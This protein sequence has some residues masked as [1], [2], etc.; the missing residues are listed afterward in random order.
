MKEGEEEEE[1]ENEGFERRDR[2]ID[3]RTAFG[4]RLPSRSLHVASG[5]SGREGEVWWRE[6]IRGSSPLCTTVS[7][8]AEVFFK[9]PKRGGR[10]STG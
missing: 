1:A 6:E 10:W 7:E 2:E 5:I 3:E 8:G 9:M 4:P